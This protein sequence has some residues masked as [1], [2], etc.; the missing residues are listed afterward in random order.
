[1]R[2]RMNKNERGSTRGEEQCKLHTRDNKLLT[3][4]LPITYFTLL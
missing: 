2:V 4:L 3:Y 1:M